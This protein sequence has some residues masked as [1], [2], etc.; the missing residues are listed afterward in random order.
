M[1]KRSHFVGTALVLSSL[2]AASTF[3]PFVGTASAASGGDNQPFDAA[4]LREALQS[5]PLGRGDA[6]AQLDPSY[7][8]IPAMQAPEFD[9][10]IPA[11]RVTEAAEVTYD[12][13]SG[14]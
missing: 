12:L 7:L 13:A 2:L 10:E 5:G 3:A 11:A 6:R 9:V 4:Q 14:T 8:S 1:L